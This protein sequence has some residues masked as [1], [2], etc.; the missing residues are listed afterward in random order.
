MWHSSVKVQE[1]HRLEGITADGTLVSF[2]FF[3]REVLAKF[4]TT[5][6]VKQRSARR[7]AFHRATTV[8]FNDIFITQPAR[9]T[10][11]ARNFVVLPKDHRMDFHDFH[12]DTTHCRSIPG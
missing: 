5:V 2:V 1:L 9:S 12:L 11:R 10:L 4:L 3:I 8:F 7:M 6:A